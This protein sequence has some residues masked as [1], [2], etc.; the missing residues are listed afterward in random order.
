MFGN[1]Y[2]VSI[3]TY[4]LLQA[5]ILIPHTTVGMLIGRQGTNQKAIQAET[6]VRMEFSPKP[7]FN[8]ITERCLTLTGSA[9]QINMAL[10]KVLEKIK[11]DPQSGS[12]PNL[13]YNMGTSL[14]GVLDPNYAAAASAV[15]L[16]NLLKLAY[17]SAN[18][19]ALT[20][21]A[22]SFA[23]PAGIFSS[24]IH[25]ISSIF[26]NVFSFIRMLKEIS[27]CI[28]RLG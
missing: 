10:D 14:N 16:E 13:V 9:V 22:A 17:A 8:P 4:F 25:F 20:N 12:C 7:D 3:K 1:R 21:P 28:S 11:S 6:G 5:K 2:L 23:Y 19:Y 26:R 18:Q 27:V 24:K 15:N